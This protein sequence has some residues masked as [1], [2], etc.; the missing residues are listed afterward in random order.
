[1]RTHGNIISRMSDSS[2]DCT[3]MCRLRCSVRP[4]GRDE[5]TR[6][7]GGLPGEKTF[8]VICQ[9]ERVF[10]KSLAPA[11]RAGETLSRAAPSHP[12]WR[13]HAI[14]ALAGIPPEMTLA[15]LTLALSPKGRGD[16]TE[17][18]R[19]FTAGHKQKPQP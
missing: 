6:E 1:M 15:P 7:A 11:R 8:G 18:C 4:V 19:G 13:S 14:Q 5:E 12:A 3:G 2:I 10:P 17:G 16:L 9:R